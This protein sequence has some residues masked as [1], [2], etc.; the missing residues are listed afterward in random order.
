MGIAT[1]DKH[2]ARHIRPKGW[3]KKTQNR[4]EHEKQ[5]NN[6]TILICSMYYIQKT[7]EQPN[8][9]LPFG[10]CVRC[11]R[12]SSKQQQEHA[13]SATILSDIMQN[14]NLRILSHTLSV[15]VCVCCVPLNIV[16]GTKCVCDRCMSV[17]VP[18]SLS[19]SFCV[20]V[21]GKQRFVLLSANKEYDVCNDM[22]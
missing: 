12:N 14:V 6:H 22:P 5:K 17:L 13:P 7:P 3:K 15:C 18:V 1:D 8:I 10:W 19:V 4:D 2:T 9:V 20:C 16:S 11:N 21:S